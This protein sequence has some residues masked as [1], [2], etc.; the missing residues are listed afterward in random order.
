MTEPSP[1][2]YKLLGADRKE[3]LSSTKGTFGG[4]KR[5]KIYGRLNCPNALRWLAK[6][7]YAKQ[8]V[9]FKDEPT[10]IAAGYS[11][12]GICMKREHAEWKAKQA[13]LKK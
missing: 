12:C 6:N 1:R 5:R 10:A 11:P 4:Y 8:R 2:M 3:Y 9:F 7:H 13:T